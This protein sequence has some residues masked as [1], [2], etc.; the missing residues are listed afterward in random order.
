MLKSVKI[1]LILCAG[2]LMCSACGSVSKAS[3][4]R[5]S[6]F[7]LDDNRQAQE[8]VLYAHGLLGTRYRYGGNHPDSGM[9]CSGMVSYIVKHVTGRTLPRNAAQI[10]GATRPV[11]RSGLQPGDLV[12]FNTSGKKYSHMGI[13]IGDGRFIHAPSS[14]KTIATAELGNSYFAK[15]FDG[16]RSLRK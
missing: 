9:D 1:V 10:A 8:I 14:G 5:S 13:Y 2:F 7:R 3:A 12:F 15:R 6:Y 4:L 16:A 11:S